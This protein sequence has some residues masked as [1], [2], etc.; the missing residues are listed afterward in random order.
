MSTNLIN[1]ASGFASGTTAVCATQWLYNIKLDQQKGKKTQRNI[2][3]LFAGLGAAIPGDALGVAIQ[4]SVFE[5]AKSSLNERNAAV[6]GGALSAIP[7]TM[8][9]IVMDFHRQNIEA[10][11][12]TTR[13]LRPSYL[14]T[15]IKLVNQ[16][17]PLVLFRGMKCT[18]GREAINALAWTLWTNRISESIEPH[19]S[20]PLISRIAGGVLSGLLAAVISHPLDTAKVK[21]QNGM[22]TGYL[23]TE[24]LSAVRKSCTTECA[25]NGTTQ[26]IINVSHAIAKEAFLGVKPR[27]G[28]LAIFITTLNLS[29]EFYNKTFQSI[30]A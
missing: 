15:I 25:K 11:G 5:R 14:Q 24:M 7:L 23:H 22:T 28:V 6:L 8:C 9:E 19:V 26:G 13:V 12:K 16:N 20:N 10:Y 1:W 27:A 3:C 21:L 4:N 2:K 18:M 29:N 17:G 30:L